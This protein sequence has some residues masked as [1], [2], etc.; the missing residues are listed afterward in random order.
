MK[1][2]FAKPY[3]SP[4]QIVQTLKSRG[5]LMKDENRVENYLM[6][7]GYHRLSAYIYPFYK[8]PKSELVLKE[9]T[10]F[11][12]ILTLYRFDKK[13]R[14]LLF[15][16]IEKIEVAIRSV[17]ANIGCQELNDR[18]WITKPEYFANADKFNQTLVFIEKELAS[19]KEDYIE[20]LRQN[21]IETYPP[22]WMI[23]EVLSFG[24]LNYIYSNISSNHLMKH[25]S[26]YFG[27][28]P[29]VFTSWLTVLAN[30]RNMCCHHARIWNRDFML[31]P[32]EP[33]KTSK[34]W[35]DTSK[36]DKKRIYYRLCM[37]RYFLSSVSPNNNFNEQLS[38]LLADFPS[39]D[40]AAMGF[41]VDW[42]DEDLWHLF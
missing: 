19:S 25:I 24:N 18:Y 27:L 15:N 20:D 30:L 34:V 29:Q 12:Q 37:L 21:F 32:A 11:E 13:L 17:L 22:A 40:I 28:K 26:G 3:S 7:I 31:N 35:I 36:V 41:P 6:N 4:G 23:T 16:E 1:T 39:I 5:M 9:G 2:S 8:S 10:T 38:G 14:I 33:R 42:K